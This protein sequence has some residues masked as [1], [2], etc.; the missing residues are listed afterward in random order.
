MFY[1]YLISTLEVCNF[2]LLFVFITEKSYFEHQVDLD[3]VRK[4]SPVKQPTSC[5]V[6][7]GQSEK[8]CSRNGICSHEVLKD[9]TPSSD[10]KIVK[11]VFYKSVIEANW[12]I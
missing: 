12:A 8:C 7:N 3:D 6:A 4:N 11:K 10:S 2:C 1:L 9:G 5:T